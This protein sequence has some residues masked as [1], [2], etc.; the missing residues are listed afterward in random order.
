MLTIN[1][2]RKYNIQDTIYDQYEKHDYHNIN[3]KDVEWGTLQ[4]GSNYH[5]AL[6]NLKTKEATFMI[7]KES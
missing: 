5:N 7:F 3:I 2:S 4:K 1:L 6:F